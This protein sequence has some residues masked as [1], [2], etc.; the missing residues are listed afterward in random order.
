MEENRKNTIDFTRSGLVKVPQ[1]SVSLQA[2]YDFNENLSADVKYSFFGGYN[3]FL[4]ED[5]KSVV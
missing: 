3:N 4:E 1:H 5:R 2:R